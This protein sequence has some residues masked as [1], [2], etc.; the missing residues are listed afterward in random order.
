MFDDLKVVRRVVLA[1]GGVFVIVIVLSAIVLAGLRDA[2][3][4][5]QLP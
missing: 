5:T 2:A 1:F 3:G 4:S